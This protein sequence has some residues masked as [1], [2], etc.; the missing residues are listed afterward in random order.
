M[1]E[2]WLP[3]EGYEG[4]YEV[5]DLGRVKSLERTI[6]AKGSGRRLLRGR[7]L[8]PCRNPNGYLAVALCKDGDINRVFVHRL[9]AKTFLTQ[10]DGKNFVNHKN[11]DRGDNRV[12]NL[13]WCTQKENIDHAIMTG[14]KKP[15]KGKRIVRSDGEIFE[16]INDA[17]RS[18]GSP[19][20][21]IQFNL[22]GKRS[23]VKGFTFAYME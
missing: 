8:K 3:V 1:Y 9:V 19:H 22:A 14:N 6:K 21:N 20:S 7:I 23:H 18:I 17:A 10:I 11:A 4:L 2:K 16:S 5:S 12:C 13:E 15:P